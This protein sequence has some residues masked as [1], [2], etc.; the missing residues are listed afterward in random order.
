LIPN[1]LASRVR[2]LPPKVKIRGY[3]PRTF[4]LQLYWYL[5]DSYSL[6]R[7]KRLWML[8]NKERKM[9][10]RKRRV[11]KPAPSVSY[12]IPR[13]TSEADRIPRFGTTNLSVFPNTN[14]T[15]ITLPGRPDS[16]KERRK[17]KRKKSHVSIDVLRHCSVPNTHY[18]TRGERKFPVSTIQLEGF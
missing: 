6:F 12:P 2:R 1:D 14:D 4:S 8:S 7:L 13:T 10:E 9:A 3:V 11:S 15:P 16:R 5:L 18:H 17:R